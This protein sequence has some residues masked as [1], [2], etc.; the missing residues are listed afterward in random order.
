LKPLTYKLMLIIISFIIM[1][2]TLSSLVEFMG[3]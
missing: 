1:V 2:R 3:N